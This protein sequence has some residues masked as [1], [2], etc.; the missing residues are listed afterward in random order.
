M[1]G[2]TA[3][4]DDSDGSS[5]QESRSETSKTFDDIPSQRRQNQSPSV[6]QK[7]LELDVD[8]LTQKANIEAARQHPLRAPRGAQNRKLNSKGKSADA[9]STEEFVSHDRSHKLNP[10]VAAFEGL[11]GNLSSRMPS[12]EPD[13]CRENVL[14]EDLF[15]TDSDF[16]RSALAVLQS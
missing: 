1:S 5:T 7:Y 11:D 4:N 2:F 13:A 9:V 6:V 16:E 10:D 12:D 8:L 14:V 3:I 15:D